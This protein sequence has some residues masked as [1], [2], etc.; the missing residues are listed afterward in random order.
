MAETL[1][2]SS[3][4]RP[5][6]RMDQGDFAMR[7]PEEFHYRD[8]AK[9][10]VLG[11]RITELTD[12]DKGGGVAEN[13]EELDRL[14]AEAIDQLIVDATP[15]ALAAITPAIFGQIFE[16]FSKLAPS[17]ADGAEASESASSSS[18]GASDS[19]EASEAA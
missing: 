14:T 6:V 5:T 1:D 9:L 8:H 2:L 3:K 11:E 16:F 17:I 10:V 18:P 12:G 13:A 19:T 15:E 4:T 7:R